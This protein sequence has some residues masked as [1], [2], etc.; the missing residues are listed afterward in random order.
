VKHDIYN[1]KPDTVVAIAPEYGCNLFSM[2]TKN[3][4]MIK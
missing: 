1:L 4:S 3:F 2:L